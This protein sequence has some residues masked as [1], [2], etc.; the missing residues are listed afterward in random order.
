MRFR[1]MRQRQYTRLEGPWRA[2][3]ARAR[4]VTSVTSVIR[5]MGA[6]QQRSRAA[7][8][9]G[10]REAEEQEQSSRSAAPGRKKTGLEA[11]R[12]W[13]ARLR[14][15]RALVS[16]HPSQYLER[17]QGDGLLGDLGAIGAHPHL[18]VDLEI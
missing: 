15:E 8:E 3:R 9:Q 2:W 10:S 11:G 13:L 4:G 7:K 16:H 18:A 14:L 6:E 5:V 1:K 12:W 17:R